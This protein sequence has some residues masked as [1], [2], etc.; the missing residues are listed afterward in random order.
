MKRREF[1]TLLGGACGGTRRA[2]FLRLFRNGCG[3]TQAAI[4]CGLRPVS[5]ESDDREI[6]FNG[7]GAGPGSSLEVV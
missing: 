2:F 6:H 5:A 3:R 4:Y 1:I 7:D